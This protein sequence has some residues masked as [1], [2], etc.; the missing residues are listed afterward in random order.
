MKKDRFIQVVTY[1]FMT[2][3][4]V[5]MGLTIL[6]FASLSGSI[7]SL[8]EKAK[9]PDF[10]QMHAGEIG[11]EEIIQFAE[12]NTGVENW[13]I[14][15]FLNIDNAMISLG[16]TSFSENNQDNGLCVQSA[17]FDYLIATDGEIPN[18]SVGHVYVPVCYRSEYGINTGDIMQIGDKS[19]VVEGF[20]RDSQM[21]SMM[22]SSKRF[23]V[24]A[25]DYDKLSEVGSEEYLI[26]FLIEDGCDV[27][28]F[29]TEYGNA[30]LPANGPTIT[31]ALIKLMNTLSDG[32]MIFVILLVSVVI[33]IISILCIRFILLTTLEKDKPEIGMM[34]AIGIS[35]FDIRRIYFNKYVV[36]AIAGSIS[37]IILAAIISNP[38][39]AQMKELYGTENSIISSILASA[40]GVVLVEGILLLLINRILRKIERLS[41]VQILQ[42]RTDK[43]KGKKKQYVLISVITAATLFLT[44]VPINIL[45]TISSD[46]FVTYMGIGDAKIRLDVRQTED[47]AGET[48]KVEEIL[49]SDSDVEKYVILQTRTVNA[50]I[51]GLVQNLLVEWGNHEEF[52]LTYVDGDAP[53][54]ECEIALSSLNAKELGVT[55]GQSVQLIIND[56]F[57]DYTVCG[58]YS[59]I[60][61]GGKT[62]KAYDN[63]EMFAQIDMP[64]MWSV[65]YISLFEDVDSNR[66][67]ERMKEYAET[68][69][70]AIKVTDIPTYVEATY[71][72]TISQIKNASIVALA[73]GMLILWIVILLFMRM[74]VEADRRDSAFKKAIGYKTS[75]IKMEYLAGSGKYVL[76]GVIAGVI[77]G[78]FLGQS[79]CGIVLGTFG[80]SKFRMIINYPYIVGLIPLLFVLVALFAITISIKDICR[81]SAREALS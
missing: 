29:A 81:I 32:M 70:I 17:K 33:L 76:S 9:T 7:D 10:L 22:A 57:V 2:I 68:E 56:E 74:I 52:S 75:D 47:I 14:C 37:G 40:I 38:L 25:E 48:G 24:S 61:N 12:S 27:N 73:A 55:T 58:I 71:S 31:R 50:V 36:L 19:L 44:I 16:G 6:L 42:K 39:S 65:I 66:W 15:E 18:V 43:D 41:A 63:G 5:L 34:K 78:I 51:D 13:Q 3:E 62:A 69:D 79:I 80:I 46:K 67:L 26:E 59:D 60:T 53:N 28:A 45:S 4:A 20:I 8:M 77:L 35:R 11:M 21:N 23:L 64:V 49:D 30:G 54:E 72:Q 1:L